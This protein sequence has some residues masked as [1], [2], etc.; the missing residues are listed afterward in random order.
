MKTRP[1]NDDLARYDG[2][3][4]WGWKGYV[5]AARTAPTP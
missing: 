2:G 5:D 3:R 4:A 1:Y